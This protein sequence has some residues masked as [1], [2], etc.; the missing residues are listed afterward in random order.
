MTAATREALEEDLLDWMRNQSW[1]DDPVR[2][3]R[4]ALGLF[5]HQFRSCPPYTRFCLSLGR[6][7]D[8]ATRIEEIPAVPTGAFK[9]FDLRCFAPEQ[10]ALTFRTSGTEATR[11]GQLHLDNVALYEASLLSS[12]RRTFIPDLVGS[13]PTLRF[14]APC[15]A[16]AP[17]SSLTYMFETLRRTEGS[18]A[19]GYDLR[20]GV[21]DLEG[22]GTAV[23]AA[24]ASGTPLVVAGTSFAFV[25]FLDA[26][27]TE[28]SSES[29]HRWR[30]PEGSRVL[31][32]GGFKGRSREV[33]RD[34]LR[35]ALA[36]SFG[37]AETHIVN[38]YGMTELGSQFYDSTIV[39]PKGPRRKLIPPWTRVRFVDPDSPAGDACDVPTGEIGL[40]VIHDLANTGSIAALQTADLGRAVVNERGI[41]IGFDVL[42]REAGAE[43]RGCSIA[44]D[45]MLEASRGRAPE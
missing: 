31:E 17:D 22:F 12:L 29:R 9:E 7:P 27:N 15:A 14:L 30:L 38:Q 44:T 23:T 28:N 16:E 45:V 2:F 41:A 32:T 21:L 1:N 18:E 11:R 35:R 20:G 25:H 13:R 19:S 43:A 26:A 39:D 40:I 5:A 42:G 4:I 6:T 33:P 37:L 8:T 3:D 34:D 36:K 10:T 24:Q